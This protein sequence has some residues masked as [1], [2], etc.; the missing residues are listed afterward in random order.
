MQ[1]Y[2]KTRP[3][4]IQFLLFLGMAFGLFMVVGLIGSMVLAKV[5]GISMLQVS[6]M[7]TWDLKDPQMISF[8]RGMLL[9]QFLGLFVIPSLLYAYFADPE[10]MH[11]L[12]LRKP[13]KPV[14]WLFALVALLIAIPFIE[15]IGML[16]QKANFGG[17]LQQ[18]MKEMEEKATRQTL[19]LLG[20]NSVENL[21]KNLVFIALFA[22]IGEELFFRGVL[23][24]LF[25]QGF[26]NAWMG[27]IVAAF[28]FS[29]FHF[30]F[31]GFFP[32]FFLGILL[33]AL[34][35]Y[36]GSLWTAMLAH[37]VYDAV[38]IVLIYLNP[39][40]AKQTDASV[41]SKDMMPVMAVVSAVLVGTLVWA[42]RKH[43]SATEAVMDAP[44][45]KDSSQKF[46]FDE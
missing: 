39:E 36:S 12:G 24:R 27:I 4:A 38:I 5:T 14:Y 29:F 17:G 30:Q 25:M 1:S 13:F 11:Y 22:G 44:E 2:L 9:L 31:F 21:L 28:V 15:Y 3:V 43:S 34:Y 8:M 6:N 16:N 33:G 32:R 42:M 41:F 19:A 35:W 20:S 26:R 23:Q 45:K 40:L 46:T 10:P 37:F 18:W 7:G